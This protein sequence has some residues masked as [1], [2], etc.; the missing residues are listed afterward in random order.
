[1]HARRRFGVAVLGL[2]LL[3]GLV[4]TPRA[5]ALVI[6]PT[7]MTNDFGGQNVAAVESAF[8]YAA[9]EYEALYTNNITINITVDDMTSGLGQSETHIAGTHITPARK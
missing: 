7:F 3:F 5:H 6:V 1:M 9:A 8:N 2:F 4:A